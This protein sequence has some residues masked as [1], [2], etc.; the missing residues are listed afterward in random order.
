[1]S[2]YRVLI[3]KELLEQ[4]RKKKILII[5]IVFLFVAVGSPIMAKLTPA[6]LR[7]ITVP[8]MTF[9]LPEPTFKD[10]I[11]QFVKNI[12]QIALLVL[13]FVVAGAISDEKLKKTLEIVL[14]KPISR[15]KFVLSKFIGY[16]L[17]I[18]AIFLTASFIFYFYT[19]TTFVSFSFANF[20]VM[21]SIILLYILMIAA[22]TILASTIVNSSILAGGIGFICYI[23][24]GTIFSLIGSITKYSPNLIFSNYLRVVSYG[25]NSDLVIPLMI[26]FV[27]IM[28]SM[29][30]SV[31]LF[32]KQEIER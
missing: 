5:G 12:S 1:V 6:I 13:V 15:A 20:S 24:I 11:S 17:S 9:K 28:I 16:F 2:E 18:S 31:A 32:R 26:I 10:S 29:I 22:I 25:W 4:W 23:L 14:T 19:V 21:A 8:G 3:G 30:L 27:L 7:S